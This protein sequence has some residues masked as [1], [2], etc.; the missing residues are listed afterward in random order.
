MPKEERQVGESQLGEA[1]SACERTVSNHVPKSAIFEIQAQA[2]DWVKVCALV[3][4][5]R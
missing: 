2:G 4:S 3:M 1:E 5:F